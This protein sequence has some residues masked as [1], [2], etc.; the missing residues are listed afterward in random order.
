MAKHWH[1]YKNDGLLPTQVSFGSKK[2]IWWICN[3]FSIS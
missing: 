3:P 1:P 2:N